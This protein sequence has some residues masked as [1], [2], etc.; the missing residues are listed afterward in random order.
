MGE[1]RS[2]TKQKILES[3]LK[4]FSRKGFK[5]TTIK[6]IAKEVG[7]TEGAIYRHFTSKDE[8][9]NELL[10]NITREL[11]EKISQSIARGG[12][13]REILKN[14]VGALL[15]YAFNHSESFR[16]LNLYHLLKDSPRVTNLPGEVILKFLRGV[17]MKGKL[18]TYPEIALAIITGSVERIFIFRER[19]FLKYE[20]EVLK[21]ELQNL[22]EDL[23][24]S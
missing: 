4:L 2:D 1:R 23:L 8:I 16:F 19:G 3:A 18:K 24:L 13:D 15:D 7:I 12:T 10:T 21:R 22:L 14:I 11:K 9:I 17:H 6:D 20:D 5:E